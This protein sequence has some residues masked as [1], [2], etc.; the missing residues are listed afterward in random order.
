[1]WRG[2]GGALRAGLGGLVDLLFPRLCPVCRN[3][4]LAESQP[5]CPGCTERIE[6]LPPG[7][8][9][10][11]ALPFV[12]VAGSTHLCADCL[13][14]EPPF[15]RVHAAG[16]YAGSLK[17]ALQLFKYSGAIELDRTLAR[18][19]CAMLPPLSGDEILLPV[20]LHPQRLR[21]RGY[22]QSLLLARAMACILQIP[23]ERTLLERVV[24]TPSQQGLD[25]RQRMSNL[26]GAF[27]CRRRLQGERML[28]V[29]D[30][31]TTGATLAA[32]SYALLDAGAGSVDG[33]VV[34]RAPRH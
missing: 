21:H 32:C 14:H 9:S 33:A 28:L 30:V 5:F 4:P 17:Q 12:A 29:D 22:N 23:L 19:L 3:A 7:R 18:L 34:G 13:R 6:P 15:G 27:R 24:A 10:R 20:P 16:L 8:C 31:M 2:G 25:A 1:M 11:C 26:H